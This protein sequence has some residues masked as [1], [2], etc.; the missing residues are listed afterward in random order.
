MSLAL[1]AK[2][3]PMEAET[4]CLWPKRCVE[5]EDRDRCPIQGLVEENELLKE[6]IR[7]ARE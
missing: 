7:V 3:K 1:T 4:R 6:E 5:C 2:I